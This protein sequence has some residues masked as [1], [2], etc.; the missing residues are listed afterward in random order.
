MYQFLDDTIQINCYETG[1]QF[2]FFWPYSPFKSHS[3]IRY[4]LRF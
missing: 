4:A 3:K 2:C 1:E